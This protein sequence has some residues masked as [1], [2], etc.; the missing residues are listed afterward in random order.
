M[1]S[2]NSFGSFVRT[3]CSLG[4]AICLLALYQTQVQTQALQKFRTR[5]KWVVLMAVFAINAGLC[6]YVVLR[7]PGGR[8]I[9]KRTPEIELAS[10]IRWLIAALLIAVPIPLYL[11]AR[12]DFFGHGMEA[13]FRL[14]W[15]AWWLML[16]QAA[17]LRLASAMDWPRALIAV[18]LLDGLGAQL[19]TLATAVSAYPFSMGWS[20]ASR[21]YYASL[22]LSQS[23]YGETFPLSVMHGTRYLLQSLP[24]LARSLPLWGARLWQVLLWIG[25][26]LGAAWGLIRRLDVQ[27][28]IDRILLAAWLFLFFFQ[29]A[30]Y[31]HLQVCV[32]L[33]LF[34]IEVRRPWLSFVVIAAAS[35][36]AGMSRV[37]WFPVP[38]ML[39]IALYLLERPFTAGRGFGDYL[40][41]PILWAATGIAFAIVGQTA[42]IWMSGNNNIEAFASSFTSALLWNRWFPSATNPIGILPGIAIVSLPSWALICWRLRQSPTELHFLRLAALGVTLLILFAGGLVVS[43]KIGG[44]GDLH[45]MD[46]YIVLLAIVGGAVL[47][48]KA[49]AER[50]IDRTPSPAPQAFMLLLVFVPVAF[51]LLRLG[52]RFHY[53]S[54]R[55]ALDLAALGHEVHTYGQSG[56]VLFMYERHL[57][58]FGLIEGVRVVPDYEV[59]TLMEMAISGNQDYLSNFY[60]DLASHRFS[61]IVAHP[62]NL[63]VETGD[64]L[65]ESEA[66]NRLVARP[67]LCQYKPSLTLEYSNV[68]VLIPRARPCPDFPPKVR[69]P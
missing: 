2:A 9:W 40:R 66:W 19:Y 11:A 25:L 63:G 12:A 28:R 35:L 62:Q 1:K 38:A 16:A 34:G 57:L 32:I 55:A 42:Y 46:A 15:A 20:E 21:Y 41:T 10:W 53:D 59:V 29:G 37:N 61:A 65:E 51:A 58:T 5:Y 24:F 69:A 8:S 33:I 64:F 26:T 67:L 52:T 48:D 47:V 54:D 50:G 7:R 6:L 4:A 27:A 44:G 68:Q 13:F 14:L 36:W 49:A 23:V 60:A 39:A 22:V 18:L 31:Y 45:N 43:T 30:V 17:G 3:Y 56:E